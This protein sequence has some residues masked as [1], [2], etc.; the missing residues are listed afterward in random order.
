MTF[1][2]NYLNSDEIPCDLFKLEVANGRTNHGISER[3]AIWLNT[4]HCHYYRT[5]DSDGRLQTECTAVM[6]HKHDIEILR[7][8]KGEIQ[9]LKCGAAKW[10]N[11]NHTHKMSYKYSSAIK[12]RVWNTEVQRALVNESID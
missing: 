8:K 4:E 12:Q 2:R 5:Y 3:D 6:G 1:K 7:D 11:D 9:E 10:S